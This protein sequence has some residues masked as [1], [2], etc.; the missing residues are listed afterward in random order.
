MCFWKRDVEINEEESA[1][2]DFIPDIIYTISEVVTTIVQILF[3]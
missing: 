1:K 2:V 3:K